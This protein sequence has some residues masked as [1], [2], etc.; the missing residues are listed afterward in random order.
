MTEM[1]DERF[2]VRT[3]PVFACPVCG[4]PLSEVDRAFRCTN[5]HTF[6]VAREGY[7]NLL[8]PQ[9]R[10]SK[11]P[12]YSKQMIASRRAFFESG[13]Y[14]RLADDIAE[15]IVSY[16][17]DRSERVIADAGCGEGYYLRRLRRL[18]TARDLES[19]TP[20]CGID[21]SKHAVRVAARLDPDGLY[22]V[23]STY[24]MPLLESRVD[25]LLS[26][27]SPVSAPDFQRV[28]RPGGVVLIGGPG[29]LHLFSL[30][31]RLYDEPALHEPE[32]PLADDPA[33]E[34][35]GVHRIRYDVA[36]RGPG[37]VASLLAMTPFYWSVNQDT[38]ESLARLDA[39]DVEV[40]VVVHAYRRV[41]DDSPDAETGP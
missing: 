13:H 14:E 1:I 10:R 7:V 20:L 28:V 38:Q 4:A 11:D 12:G 18:L 26:Q 36:L 37:Q 2:R 17:S 33:F 34:P 8:L 9:Q 21:V 5:E 29:E 19:R 24:R 40:D 35:I 23:A 16:A 25:V 27:F 15:L 30:K 39:L 41:G 32:E 6:D 3:V 22:A 31:G